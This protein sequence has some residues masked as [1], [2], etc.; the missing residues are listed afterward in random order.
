MNVYA[1]GG[2]QQLCTN[3]E[4]GFE[5]SCN[6]GFALKAD[7]SWE[8]IHWVNTMDAKLAHPWSVVAITLKAFKSMRLCRHYRNCIAFFPT[9]ATVLELRSTIRGPFTELS[10]ASLPL[11]RKN[12]QV[13]CLGIGSGVKQTQLNDI[14][15]SAENVFSATSFTELTPVA[16]AIVARSC[17]GKLEL[18]QIKPSFRALQTET[19]SGYSLVQARVAPSLVSANQR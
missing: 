15:S 8:V 10:E 12:I 2:C 16:K 6:E 18:N 11:K 1:N 19:S 17:S 9:S 5:C 14:A 13:Y 7:K 3:T 4:G